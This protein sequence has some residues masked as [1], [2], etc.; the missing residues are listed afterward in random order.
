MESGKQW[1]KPGDLINNKQPASGMTPLHI[2]ALNASERCVGMLLRAG[3]LVHMRDSLGHTA[4]YYVSTQIVSLL[5]CLDYSA[6]IRPPV[7]V[8]KA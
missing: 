1:T 5:F 2:A 8:T 6:N 4:L 7:K 3:A